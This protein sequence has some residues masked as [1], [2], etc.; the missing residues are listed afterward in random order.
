[1]DLGLSSS[2]TVLRN[3][4]TWVNMG[5]KNTSQDLL[6]ITKEANQSEPSEHCGLGLI[7][8]YASQRHET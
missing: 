5:E 4:V 7:T 6:R 2:I 1:M 8:D 3:D